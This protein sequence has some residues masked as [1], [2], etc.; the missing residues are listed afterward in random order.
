M[1]N[2]ATMKKHLIIA[3][4]WLSASTRAQCHLSALVPLPN[5][6]ETAS[7]ETFTVSPH[8]EITF[9]TSELAFAAQTLQGELAERMGI[10][11]DVTLR[12][13]ASREGSIALSVDKSVAGN[14]HYVLTV[15]KEGIDVKGGSAAAVFY[16]V[17]TLRQ[18]LM[19]DPCATRSRKIA[20]T[21]I[22]DAPRF[23][24]R[25]LMLDPARHFLPVDDVKHYIDQMAH[26][27]YN[28]LQLHLTDDQGWRLEVRDHPQLT[29][30]QEHYRREDLA[31]IIRYAA[32]R[33]IQVVPEIDIPGHTVAVL[34]AF[35]DLGCSSSDTIAKVVGKTEH[36]MLCAANDRVYDLYKHIIHE[37]A[38]LFPSPY[39]H[40]GGDE[41]NI[42]RNWAKCS[43]C[44]ALMKKKGYTQP[45]QLM[46][47]FFRKMLAMVR[48]EGKKPV[49]W[50]ELD[51]IY[52]P[53]HDYL[54]PYDRDVTL[55][56]WR[57]GL[58]PTCLDLT[59]RHGNP[60]I[61]APG[62]YCYFDY[63]QWKGDL[64][65][66][67]NWGMPTTPLRK[68][69][70]LDP[71]YGR[72]QEEQEHIMGVMGTLWGEA[73]QDIHRA[74][75]MTYPRGL[76]LAEA[77]WTRMELR[78]WESFRQRLYPNLADMMRRGVSFRVPYEIAV[79]PT[80]KQ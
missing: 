21:R 6:M 34:A 59:R 5:H 73:I 30:G 54:F 71:G 24:Y 10:T 75:Y 40:L 26:Y 12:K 58:T 80:S 56:T 66:F 72:S 11:L 63:P 18:M 4:L 42:G 52:P 77:G 41:A 16:G 51:N 69:Y 53:A 37:V 74:T 13:A 19:G 70:E 68:C 67:N 50:C 28:V 46:I 36:L 29:A 2:F 7:G 3:L 55:V 57:G 44:Q 39:I 14:E 20:A 64:P 76:A 78:D 17:M 25:A 45:E 62:E 48:K 60:I 49:L 32:Q 38:T 1:R 27:K 22:D 61:M 79:S 47:P 43:H 15:G 9:G 35:P 65:E 23:G 31:E 8:C 33:H